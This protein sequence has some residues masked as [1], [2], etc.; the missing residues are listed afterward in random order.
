VV[1]M[2]AVMVVMVV[3]PASRSAVMAR[4][5][6]AAMT[7]GALPV[8]TWERSSSKRLSRIQRRIAALERG[9]VGSRTYNGRVLRRTLGFESGTTG[10]KL[11]PQARSS[12]GGVE[13]DGVAELFELVDQPPCAVFGAASALGPVGPR[14]A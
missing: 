10:A 2:A 4:L 6:S 3:M 12:G 5:R 11:G 9:E 14:S 7:W 1:R 8:R 13:G